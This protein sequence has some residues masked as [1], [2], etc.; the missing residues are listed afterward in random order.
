MFACYSRTIHSLPSKT[1]AFAVEGRL[2]SMCLCNQRAFAIEGTL[3]LKGHCMAS[4][5]LCD[6]SEITSKTST[7]RAKVLRSK[8]RSF[9]CIFQEVKSL[10]IDLQFSSSKY[11][12]V[13]IIEFRPITIGN[14]AM[15][16]VPNITYEYY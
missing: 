6:R 11:G 7:F 14:H 5:G 3:P 8:R 15:A 16:M 9:T 10:P 12:T 4:K 2:A 13:N 1:S